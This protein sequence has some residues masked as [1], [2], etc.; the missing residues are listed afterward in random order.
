MK[1]LLLL[2]LINTAYVH[3]V[4]QVDDMAE[5]FTKTG[6][7]EKIDYEKKLIAINYVVNNT[8]ENELIKIDNAIFIDEK[9]KPITIDDIK[10]SDK[11]TIVGDKFPEE[12]NNIAKSI[13]L[14]NPKIDE[15]FEG[16]VDYIKDDFAIVN[17]YK[18]KL[19]AGKKIKGK[20]KSGYNGDEFKAFTEIKLGILADVS[21]DL[22]NDC[23]QADKFIIEP[24]AD[25]KYNSEAIAL[26]K[27]LY[28]KYYPIWSDP[29]K[30]TSVFNTLIEGHGK[31][32]SDAQIQEYV[33]SVAQKLIPDHLKK[34]VNFI[35]IVV[36]NAEPTATVRANGLA[37]VNSGLLMV[38][39]NE[40]QLAAVL[41]HEISHVLYK[42]NS[43]ELSSK[44]NAEK[45]KK[46]G[47]KRDN[48]ISNATNWI[49]D[50]TAKKD[51][52]TVGLD[53]D[54]EKKLSAA[55]KLNSSEGVKTLK[56]N[57]IDKRT[58]NYSVA[59]ELEA[60]RVG[61]SLMALA[62]Y[63]TREAPIVW[64]NIIS[65]YEV[66]PNEKNGVSLKDALE[67][68]I[69]AAPKAK[70][71]E[72][73]PKKENGKKTTVKSK[74]SNGKKETVG[75]ENDESEKEV[76]EDKTILES[77]A[78]FIVKWKSDDFKAKSYQSHPQEVKRFEELNKLIAAM[79]NNAELY[80]TNQIVVNDKKYQQI[81]KKLKG[82]IKS[83]KK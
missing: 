16:R 22:S 23:I 46:N 32:I 59:Q 70:E 7:V 60:D 24:P 69:T 61:L 51:K 80:K 26:D 28:D 42:H 3:S 54:K 25:D 63:D 1:K 65:N 58:S 27:E 8:I 68:E 36:E 13:T 45:S 14:I 34:K 20:S 57:Y 71:V 2:L 18:V 49:K 82:K 81:K 38:L 48:A 41:G 74:T 35:F 56:L 40:A 39:D 78:T 4:A 62:G 77:T 52:E 50:K 37:F 21:G 29:K 15:S 9:K 79:W 11:V 43:N 6:Y 30:R 73:E 44:E 33:E 64:K 5:H 17:G 10:F 31:I 76:A 55:E 53:E 19:K 66:D 12:N 67:N 75:K 47:E 83:S 72:K